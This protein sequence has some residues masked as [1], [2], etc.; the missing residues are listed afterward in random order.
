MLGL[1]LV[2]ILLL[3]TMFYFSRN[4]LHFYIVCLVIYNYR[5]M[6]NYCGTRI[7]ERLS[8]ELP[9]FRKV[10]IYLRSEQ[11]AKCLGFL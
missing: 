3:V 9:P 8:S 10:S 11:I 5:R 4:L 6:K 1:F 2:S 7:R